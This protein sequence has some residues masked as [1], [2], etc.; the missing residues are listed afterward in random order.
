MIHSLLPPEEAVDIPHVTP[1]EADAFVQ[2]LLRRRRPAR[3]DR[4][5]ELDQQQGLFHQL[6]SRAHLRERGLQQEPVMLFDTWF[7]SA[8]N[9]PRCSIARSIALPA[10]TSVWRGRLMRLWRDRRHPHFPVDIHHVLPAPPRHPGDR[11]GGHLILLQHPSPEEAGVLFSNYQGL[12]SMSPN[13]RFAELVPTAL[14]LARILWHNDWEH[15]CEQPEVICQGFYGNRAIPP[16][17]VWPAAH[18]QHIEL[19]MSRLSAS[20]SDSIDSSV[21]LQTAEPKASPEPQDA[22]DVPP[23]DRH[24]SSCFSFN[25]A[26]RPF[27]PNL[28]LL[29]SQSEFVQ[30][31]HQHWSVTAFAWEDEDR[32]TNVVTYF[33]NHLMPQWRCDQGRIVNLSED[34]SQWEEVISAAWADQTAPGHTLTFYV[35]TPTPPGIEPGVAAYVIVVQS[36][37][38]QLVTSR[39]ALCPAADDCDLGPELP[40]SQAQQS[41]QSVSLETAI[42]PPSFVLLDF[43]EVRTAQDRILG[44]DLGPILPRSSIVKWHAATL[45]ALEPLSDWTWE[46]ALGFSFF[47]DGSAFQDGDSRCASAAVVLIVHTMFGDRFGGFR[48]FNTS[49]DGHAPHAEAAAMLTATLWA[50]QACETASQWTSQWTSPWISFH[51]DCLFAGNSAQGWWRSIAHERI[52]HLTR[53]LVHW[54]S[55]RFGTIPSWTH[56]PAHTGH[57]WNEAADAAAWAAASGWIP[58][59]EFDALLQLVG[60]PDHAPHWLW[61]LE[62]AEQRHPMIPGLDNNV[63]RVNA[64]QAFSMIPACDLHPFAHRAELASLPLQTIHLTLRCATAN[65][66]SLYS[67]RSASGSGATARLESLLQAFDQE[68]VLVIGAQETRSRLTG[69]TVCQEYHIL[70]SSATD[71]GVGGVQL[72]IRKQWPTSDGALHIASQ[73]LRIVHSTSQ[74]MLVQL[75]HHDLCLLF[76]VAHAPA[77]PSAEEAHRFWT[78]LSSAIPSSLRSWPMI[79]LLDANARL[80]SS[81]SEAVGPFGA[82]EENLAGEYFHQWLHDRSLFVPQTFSEHHAGDHVTWTHSS[83]QGARLDFI[84]IDQSLRHPDV[85]TGIANVDL[86]LRK[87]DHN[88][89]QIDIPIVCRSVSRK[90]SPSTSS[91][92]SPLSEPPSIPW[93][94]DVHTHAAQLQSWLR[95][96][97]PPKQRAKPRKTHLQ[98]S[99]WQLIRCKRFHWN[100]LRHLRRLL[101]TATLRELF[102]AWRLSPRPSDPDVSLPWFRLID[103]SIALHQWQHSRLCAQVALQVREDDRL[104]YEALAAQQGAVAADEGLTGLWSQ[105]RHLLPKGIKRRKHNIRCTGPSVDEL[106]AHYSRLEAGLEVPYSDLLLQCHDRQ[107]RALDELPLS[108]SLRDLPT[109]VELEQVCKLAKRGRA[110]GLDQ[111]P[112][113]HLQ[114]MM[115]HHSDVFFQLFFKVWLL[116]AEP[117]QWKGGFICSIAKKHGAMTASGMRGIMLLD[118]LGKLHHALLRRHLLPWAASNRLPTQFGGFKGQQT[119]FASLQLRSY[120]RYV[121][122]K[123]V[124]LAIVFIDVRNAFHCLLRQHAFATTNTFPPV[125]TQLLIAEGLD[126]VQ[127]HADIHAHAHQ[128]EDAPAAVQRLIR[129]A[130][131][132]TWFTCPG[133]DQCFATHRGSRPGSPIA[134]LACNVLM[135]ALLRKLQLALHDHPCLLRAHAF[136]ECVSPTITWVDDVA[137]PIPCLHADEVDQLLR[138]TMSIVH[139]TFEHF[140]LRLNSAAGKTEAIVQY[141]GPGAPDLRRSRFVDNFGRLDIPGHDDL[142]IVPHYVHLGIVIAQSCDMQQDLHVKLG[143]ASAAFRTMSKTIFFNRRLRVPL[144]LKLL[145]T[146]ILPIIFYGSGSWPLLTA[147]QYRTLSSAITTWQRKIVG[148]GYWTDTNISDAAF[149]AT[150]RIPSLSVR[151][152]KHRL[153]FFLQLHRQGP[154]STWDMVLAEDEFCKS[155][156]LDAVRHALRWFAGLV[157]ELPLQDWTREELLTWGAQAPASMSTQIRRAVARFLTQEETIHHVAKMHQEIKSLCQ[158]HGVTFDDYQKVSSCL[159]DSFPCNQC[160]RIFST[161]QG[162]NAHAWKAHGQISS[163]RRYVYSGVCESCR[164]CFWT[165]QRLQ[166]HLRYSRKKPDGCYWWL[167]QHMDP[168]DAPLPVRMPDVHHGQFRL[169]WT[170][171]AGPIQDVIP[172]KWMRDHDH[173]WRLWKQAWLDE[174]LPDDLSESLCNDVHRGLCIATTSWCDTPDHDLSWAWCEVI[175]QYAASADS[176]HLQAMWAFALWGRQGMYDLIDA[177]DDVDHKLHIEEKYLELASDLPLTALLDRLDRLQRAIPPDP[178][179]PPP[180]VP[181]PDHRAQV[182]LEPFS[183][184]YDHADEL[185]GPVTNPEVL[186]WPAQTG[187]PVCEL[188]DGRRVLIILHL[189]S[190]RRREGDCHDWAERLISQFFPDYGVMM[191]S[192]DTAVGGEHCNLL[193][194]PG[195]S[196]LHRLVAAGLVSGVLSGPPCETWSAAR[197]LEPPAPLRVRWPRPLRSAARAWGLPHLTHRELRQ[198]ATGSALMMSNVKIEI[199]VV[200]LGGAAIQ[201]HPEIPENEAYASVWRTPLQSRLCKAAP[202]HQRLHIQQWRYGAQ[203]VKPTLLRLMGLPPSAAVLHGQAV[204]G[205]SRP[206]HHLSGVDVRTGQFKTASAKEYP[207]DLCKAMVYTLFHGL[208][209]RRRAEGLQLRFLSLLGEQDRTWLGCVQHLAATSFSSEFLP[210][211]QPQSRPNC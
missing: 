112:A 56:V 191:L 34:Y 63:M 79:A 40:C 91:T 122:A 116:S 97:L 197:H 104:F 1:L 201:E 153:L 148:V 138:D 204:P 130:H 65:V 210:D 154:A 80:G 149:R 180:P 61:F 54:I 202:G 29:A 162:L 186:S 161:V 9:F 118:T 41:R 192:I 198:V 55:C 166:Q 94:C 107:Q 124:S 106:T 119:I 117:V 4:D 37:H 17:I 127:L 50:L 98:D 24:E 83:G 59:F 18:G 86:T 178:E 93:A 105:I 164:R 57:P 115:A 60:T 137:L 205:L 199:H 182:P 35:V 67:T 100:R 157:P 103:R 163:E 99:T 96:T 38:E 95:S 49:S 152:A 145:D 48:C 88:S 167:V 155:S 168:L 92:S 10:D 39:K 22:I 82:E 165:S 51:F 11:L 15:L 143:K 5:D 211:Y 13:D 64:S 78:T 150:W 132:D 109:R 196:S 21:L 174:G 190:G 128:F 140:G 169:P 172:T 185:L 27:A 206:D 47:T 187:I 193:D 62:L 203:A 44:L 71:K 87:P 123:Q 66:L 6:W 208:A 19:H 69:H 195:L 183:G 84:A 12:D 135:T 7:L 171:A 129:D 36:E 147:S 31:L 188:E 114:Y 3:A 136:L 101:R 131:Q 159:P 170:S 125:L 89:V 25:A 175:E 68:Q 85:R 28:P 160:P 126:P 176:V 70:S 58:Q 43:S 121:A 209:R 113:E 16:D 179:C 141:R 146:L 75:R 33:A 23:Q 144:R 177:I 102:Q 189:F 45:E 200:L 42:P 156:W 120:A 181:A 53:A 111:V 194:G 158:Q 74:S 139:R 142:R 8:L 184:A 14:T 173:A 30:D 20:A 32:S 108:V 90:S 73:H 207:S 52:Q 2:P 46:E 110:P 151:L 81:V 134:D 26:A 77:C 133:T 72:W 76:L